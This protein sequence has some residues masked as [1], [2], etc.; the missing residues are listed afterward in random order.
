[1]SRIPQSL[2]ELQEH[3]AEQI[4]FLKASA[5]AFDKGFE[6]ESKRLAVALRVLLHDTPKSKSLLGQLE[7]KDHLFYDTR[8]P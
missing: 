4:Y 3:F 1:M 6:G 2:D 7:L 8:M 5:D